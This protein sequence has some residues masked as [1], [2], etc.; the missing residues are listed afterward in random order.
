V[1]APSFPQGLWHRAS[2]QYFAHWRPL[3]CLRCHGTGHPGVCILDVHDMQSRPCIPPRVQD[4]YEGKPPPPTPS[5][6]GFPS[7]LTVVPPSK[8]CTHSFTKC[9]PPLSR[10]YQKRRPDRPR[11]ANI[12]GDR[13]SLHAGLTRSQRYRHPRPTCTSHSDPSKSAAALATGD[14]AQHTVA[15]S[16]RLLLQFNYSARSFVH[17]YCHSAGV[18]VGLIPG[19][20]VSVILVPPCSQSISPDLTQATCG[21]AASSS[22]WLVRSALR[23]PL[24]A[25]VSCS[26]SASRPVRVRV[27]VGW[28]GISAPTVHN[29]Y[30]YKL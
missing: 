10:T 25:L 9:T 18:G 29:T 24:S 7:P 22:T 17:Y 23:S 12:V 21:R 11:P 8:P 27:W 28:D 6:P 26:G 3:P 19:L 20:L 30:P 14:P 4:M 5:Y 16:P 15:P 1:H 13:T 2:D